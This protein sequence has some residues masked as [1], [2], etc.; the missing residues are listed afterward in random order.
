[1]PLITDNIPTQEGLSRWP[2]LQKVKIPEIWANI[3]LLIRTN[4]SKIMELWDIIHSQGEGPY[5]VRSLVGWVVS[6]PLR[7]G[8]SNISS[9]CQSATMNRISVAKLKKLLISQYNRDFNEKTSKEKLEMSFTKEDKRFLA[10]ANGSVSLID[11]HYI[12]NLSFRKDN[13]QMPNNHAMTSDPK[14]KV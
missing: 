2:Y 6:G 10:I 14:K 12:L 3:E 7:D 9:D 5:A 13:V 11:G 8:A 4:A 1:M